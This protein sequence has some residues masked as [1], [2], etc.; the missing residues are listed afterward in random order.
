MT[1]SRAAK[2]YARALFNAALAENIVSSVDD[3]MAGISA[4]LASSAR[5]RDFLNVPTT[6][7]SEK[8]QLLDNVFSD[9]VTA[10]TMG[11]I[12]LLVR[13]RR[14]DM[15]H[16]IQIEFAE[17]R[18]QHEGVT[19]AVIESSMELG[20]DQ[21]NAIVAKIH[22]ATGRR[23]EPEFRIDSTLMGGVKVTYDNYV[24]D[25]TVRGSLNRLRETL[26]YDLLKQS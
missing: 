1:D 18:R 26:I 20:E 8:L 11:F 21:K 7:D 13:K 22:S 15:I 5:V 2:R 24:L 9:R 16:A 19:K 23:V 10:L 6:T 12:R 3:D 17:L 4:V 25:G 14:D